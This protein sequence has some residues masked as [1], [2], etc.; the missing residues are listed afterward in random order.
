VCQLFARPALRDPA[1]LEK[2]A[3]VLA[4]QQMEIRERVLPTII[5]PQQIATNPRVGIK[6]HSHVRPEPFVLHGP[7]RL[8]VDV[9]PDELMATVAALVLM[10]VPEWRGLLM[11]YGVRV[12]FFQG[13]PPGQPRIQLVKD[14]PGRPRR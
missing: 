5:D 11:L 1:S 8:G 4:T 7:K 3:D 14:M 12:E 2:L 6:L 13:T 10:L 9:A